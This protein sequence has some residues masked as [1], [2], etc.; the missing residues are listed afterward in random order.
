MHCR[1]CVWWRGY[2]GIYIVNL[3]F[4]YYIKSTLLCKEFPRTIS[5]NH[6]ESRILKETWQ[7]FFILYGLLNIFVFF[8][9][10][11]SKRNS[12]QAVTVAYHQEAS[13]VW[14]KTS[15]SRAN[16]WSPSCGFLWWAFD[17]FLAGSSDFLMNDYVAALKCWHGRHTAVSS[18]R[19]QYK[20][21]RTSGSKHQETCLSNFPEN[22]VCL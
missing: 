9:L 14:G 12:Q 1:Q 22:F 8:F 3:K 11:L 2:S 18:K 16:T 6:P 4:Q 19:E 5:L 20:T 10:A 17:C 7:I 13:S 21:D 15:A